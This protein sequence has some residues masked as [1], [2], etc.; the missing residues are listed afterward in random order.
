MGLAEHW[1]QDS[2]RYVSG[3]C[4]FSGQEGMKS[5]GPSMTPPLGIYELSSQLIFLQGG[6]VFTM[7]THGFIL[8]L[9]YLSI[10]L[11]LPPSFPCSLFSVPPPLSPPSSSSWLY[12]LMEGHGS[13]ANTNL[14]LFFIATVVSWVWKQKNQIARKP[15]KSVSGKSG[16]QVCGS[17][18][19]YV[20]F[21]P[22]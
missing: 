15:G 3:C 14:Q 9:K 21:C 13:A 1:L 19:S 11:S 20:F 10:F 22:F 6:N 8:Y 7:L 5:C 12:M 18:N 2:A 16:E 17:V 4:L